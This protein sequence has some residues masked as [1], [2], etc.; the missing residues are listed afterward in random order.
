MR[1]ALEG[2]TAGRR[3]GIIALH[4]EVM[5]AKIIIHANPELA[6]ASLDA[7]NEVWIGIAESLDGEDAS[8]ELKRRGEGI[9]ELGRRSISISR[10]LRGRARGGRRRPPK[11]HLGLEGEAAPF[12]DEIRR[13]VKEVPCSLAQPLAGIALVF[14]SVQVRGEGRADGKRRLFAPL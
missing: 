11:D 7:R 10:P 4:F 3:D 12:K 2:E 5:P 1:R 13:S 6:P 14:G 8:N 9:R